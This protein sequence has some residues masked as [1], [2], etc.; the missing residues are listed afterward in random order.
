VCQGPQA[1]LCMREV[2]GSVSGSS[3]GSGLVE[4]VGLPMGG[5]PLQ[6]L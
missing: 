1:G 5:F 2:G 6:F 4:T 3:M